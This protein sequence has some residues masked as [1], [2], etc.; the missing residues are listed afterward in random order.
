MLQSDN[1]YY[2]CRYCG[3]TYDYRYNGTTNVDIWIMDLGVNSYDMSGNEFT[4]IIYKDDDLD[5]NNGLGDVVS[6][7]ELIPS[8]SKI[9]IGVKGG[10]NGQW[11]HLYDSS[12]KPSLSFINLEDNSAY[13]NMVISYRT[14]I[15]GWRTIKAF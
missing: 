5:I 13:H 15:L 1:G 11:K 9:H 8:G 7:G 4:W 2:S 12:N 3:N 10:T 14:A 6:Y